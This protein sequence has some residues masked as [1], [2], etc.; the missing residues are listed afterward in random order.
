[1]DPRRYVNVGAAQILSAV[2]NF[3]ARERQSIL[4]T[5]TAESKAAD[6]AVPSNPL[7]ERTVDGQRA[8][9]TRGRTI[10]ID[11]VTEPDFALHIKHPAFFTACLGI[12][13]QHYA[14]FAI[15]R[16]PLSALLSWRDAGTMPISR[17]HAP[18]AEHFDVSLATRLA[19]QPD[20][21]ERQFILLDWYF[22]QYARHV[23]D[24]VIKYEHI[25][26][27]GGRALSAINKHAVALNEVLSS[28][29]TIAF[30]HDPDAYAIAEKLLSH[31]G[32][33]CW[34][35]YQPGDVEALIR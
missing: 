6:G 27:T 3:F 21:L 4:A 32:N 16:N 9:L 5:G 24:R 19:D 14:C 28:R 10:R 30:E 12:L 17:G 1:M 25:V 34:Q 35:F 33:A 29:N 20:V 11:N 31:R 8:I 26:E 7:G 2:Q 18:M 15:V 13:T 22:G 23:A